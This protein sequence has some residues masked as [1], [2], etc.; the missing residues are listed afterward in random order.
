MDYKKEFVQWG[1]KGARVIVSSF[2]GF[3]KDGCALRASSLT[4]YTLFAI[5]PIMAMAFGIAK[6]FGFQQ[7][8]EGEVLAMFEGQEEIIQKVLEFSTNLLDKTRGGPMAILGVILLMYSLVKLMGHIEN[9]FNRIWWVKGARP[10]VRK[11]A[12]Y[13]T[14]S[15]TAGLLVIFSSSANIFVTTHLEKFLEFISLPA[16][17]ERL[18]SL[19]FNIFPFI[20][21]WMLFAFFYVIIP[22]TKIDI[23][24]AVVGAFMAGTLFQLVQIGYLKFQVGVSNYNAIYGSFAALPLFLIWLQ[25]SWAILLY[26]AEI[27]FAWEN[28]GTLE[29]DELGYDNL[30]FRLEKLIAL[31]IIVLCVKR[32]AQGDLPA[33]DIEIS[34][35][36]RLPLKIIKILLEKLLESNLL[37]EVMSST[38][39][40]GYSPAMDIET[41][42]IMDVITAFEQPKDKCVQV[43]GTLEFEAL[44]ESLNTFT[45]V[46]K[47]SSGERK[48]KDI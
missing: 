7:F 39:Q 20:S 9:A 48:L 46:A 18:I 36:L 35:E 2:K 41:A 31:R 6:G 30:S 19:G 4:L 29:I 44:E 3:Q 32:F 14:I 26:G 45:R 17:L 38:N 37:Y 5:V 22:N 28:A 25:V 24:A 34:K 40:S 8:F 27:A 13:M 12:D 33:T 42:S 1:Q 16:G 43:S 21:I 23:N 47:N 15:I 10:I 11:V